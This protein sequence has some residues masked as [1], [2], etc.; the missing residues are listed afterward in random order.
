[1]RRHLLDHDREGARVLQG[2]RAAAQLRPLPSD[3]VARTWYV[4]NLWIDCGVRPTCPITGMPT[5]TMRRTVGADDLA[6]FD[7]D[8][9]DARLLAPC[10]RRCATPRRR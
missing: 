7:L 6:A 2:E 3:S 1:V 9:L 4:P 10:G 8:G 5:S